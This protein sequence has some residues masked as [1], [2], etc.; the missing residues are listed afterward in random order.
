MGEIQMCIAYG[1]MDGKTTETLYVCTFYHHFLFSLYFNVYTFMPFA[2]VHEWIEFHEKL[3]LNHI[4]QNKMDFKEWI[5][6]GP[7]FSM[8]TS[9]VHTHDMLL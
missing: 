1:P 3:H 4:N 8:Y 7:Y 5:T 6:D 2:H 9:F